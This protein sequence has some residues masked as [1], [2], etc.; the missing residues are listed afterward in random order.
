VSAEAVNPQI[1]IAVVSWNTRDLLHACLNSMESDASNG[2]AD[3][4]VVDN[5]STDGSVDLVRTAHPWVKLV[6]P[7]SN[8]GFGPAVNLVA[9]ETRTPWIAPANAD[10][11]LTPGAI[12]GLLTAAEADRE[13]GV[14]A[15]KLILPDGTAQG[16]VQPFP[17]LGVALLLNL[18]LNLASE[19][20]AERLCLRWDPDRAAHVDWVTGA[21]LLVR[22]EVYEHVG[23][24]DER[25]WMY[26]EDLD[27]CW[28]VRRAGWKVRYEPS[29]SVRH[30]LSAAAEQAF[31]DEERRARRW[32]WANY[33]W[34]A[35]RKGV[36]YARLVAL[37]N[38]SGAAARL[39]LYSLLGRWLEG[40]W[41]RRR[42]DERLTLR[43]NRLGLKASAAGPARP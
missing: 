34:L 22:R 36:L 26:A 20:V 18:R 2:L 35:R 12:A 23:G 30:A 9:R 33:V 27:L 14:I 17:L 11:E 43:L 5:G 29:A 7:G 13:A 31:G 39:T 32:T 38:V 8:L 21:F 42:H 10:I 37:V 19:R 24:F 16:S 4:W 41:A 40:D 15:P 25:Q 3:V 6:V 28:R 1:T